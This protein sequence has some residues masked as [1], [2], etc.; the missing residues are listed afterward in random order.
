[1]L[2]NSEKM[3]TR[4]NFDTPVRNNVEMDLKISKY[5]KNLALFHDFL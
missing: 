5:Q 4:E 2:F 1:M 3:E